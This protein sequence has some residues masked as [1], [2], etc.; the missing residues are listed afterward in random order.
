M[1]VPLLDLKAQYAGIRNEILAA[2]EQVLASQHFILGPAVTA[3][4][5]QVADLCSI[6]HAIGVASG[7]DA[8]LLSLKA[9][10]VGPGDSVVTVPFT[11]FATAG[12]VVHAGAR[13]L[14]VDVRE[15]TLSMDSRSLESFLARDCTSD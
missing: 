3:L 9:L 7:S 11:F 5:R 2:V 4:E 14:F 10:G 8:L 13:P 15:D 12:S 6:P 1:E